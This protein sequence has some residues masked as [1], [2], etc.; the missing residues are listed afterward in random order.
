MLDP[1]KPFF[2][3]LA[4]IVMLYVRPH[5]YV[6]ALTG[7]PILPA[8][9]ATSFVLWLARQPKNWAAPQFRLV[10]A[11]TFF[12]AVSVIASGWFMGGINV[13]TD[14]TP[15][16]LLFFMIATSVDSLQ[17]L[18]DYF[19]VMG[20]VML[21][22]ALHSIDQADKGI[23]WTGAK[24]INERVAYLG[25]LADP[26]DLSMAFLMNLPMVIYLARHAGWLMRI[27]WGG[28]AIAIL[29]AIQLANSRGAVLSLGVMIFQYGIYRFGLKRS[30]MMG[31]VM[32]LPILL[33][34][35]SRMSEMSSDEESA[36]GRID[37]WYEGFDM[38]IHHP[39]FGVGKGQFVEHHYL[40]AHN[41]Y[42]LALAELGLIGFFF[43]ISNITLTIQMARRVQT[44][45]ED[46]IKAE[47][48]AA[49]QATP[50]NQ[51]LARL[52]RPAAA[53]AAPSATVTP[54]LAQRAATPQPA[55]FGGPTGL[56][57]AQQAPLTETWPEV[58]EAMRTLWYGYLGGMVAMYFLS[59]S[60]VAILYVHMALIIAMYQLARRH[61]PEIEN[62]QF[63]DRKGR[64]VLT[65][66]GVVFV[67][68]LMTTILLRTK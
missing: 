43:W 54:A 34:G 64:M 49:A 67:L 24:M 36:E 46:S 5:D 60:Y 26:N 7:L 31:P 44:S 13:I 42:V 14:F 50:V 55:R 25:F 27:F 11:Q 47:A 45:G 23:G 33:F 4:Y 19:T 52:R 65:A 39:L 3:L 40:T 58:W 63:A 62:L 16:V 12:M 18:K 56:G 2:Y 38:L 61:R 32:L 66:L 41:S 17:R 30:L 9:L 53:Q 28:T 8:L 6:P 15:V 48:E 68:W 57:R 21:V 20:L 22:I 35:P 37:A 51:A 10:P 59:R 1:T 29:Y